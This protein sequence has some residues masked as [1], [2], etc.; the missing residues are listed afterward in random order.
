MTRPFQWEGG[1]LAFLVLFFDLLS[2]VTPESEGPRPADWPP[3]TP[4]YPCL[5]P[6]FPIR[7]LGI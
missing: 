5:P 3:H 2:Q 7:E 6:R 4:I 1:P